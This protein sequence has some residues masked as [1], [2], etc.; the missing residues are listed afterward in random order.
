MYKYSCASGWVQYGATC[1]LFKPTFNLLSFGCNVEQV[2]L[3]QY[4]VIPDV[5]RNDWTKDSVTAGRKIR[6][7]TRKDS[8]KLTNKL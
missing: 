5:E 1:S 4:K 2:I 7:L 8:R 3:C 6:N